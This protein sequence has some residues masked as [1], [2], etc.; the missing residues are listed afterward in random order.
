MIQRIP[1]EDLPLLTSLNG[2]ARNGLAFTTLLAAPG[3][4]TAVCAATLATALVTATFQLQAS[5]DGTTFY[6]IADATFATPQASSQTKIL[7]F[8]VGA[9]SYAFVRV[10]ATLAGAATSP[11]G[12]L[13][14]VTLY[15]VPAGKLV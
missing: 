3:T 6:D 1:Y 2:V 13:T 4:I 8:P 12:D 9:H 14:Q 7:T 15:Y 10:V 11:S 5:P